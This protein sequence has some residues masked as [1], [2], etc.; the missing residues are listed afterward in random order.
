MS[1][2][3][4]QRRFTEQERIGHGTRLN[5]DIGHV[6][7]PWATIMGVVRDAKQESRANDEEDEFYTA[8][9]QLA[10][11]DPAQALAA[12]TRGNVAALAWAIGDAI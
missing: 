9:A 10:W 5:P 4:A 11:A 6:D 2:S 3:L 1:E 12:G 8:T 7:R